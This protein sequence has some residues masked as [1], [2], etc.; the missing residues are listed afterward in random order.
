MLQFRQMSFFEAHAKVLTMNQPSCSLEHTPWTQK[1]IYLLQK[2]SI[3]VTIKK[4]PKIDPVLQKAEPILKKT[5]D[6]FQHM[7]WIDA[8]N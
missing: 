2:T 3:L 4:K 7:K 8:T 6:L 5:T 1:Y